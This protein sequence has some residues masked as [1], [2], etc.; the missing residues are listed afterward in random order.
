MIKINAETFKGFSQTHGHGFRA[1]EHIFLGM[2][3]RLIFEDT[4][5]QAVDALFELIERIYLI[6]DENY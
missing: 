1:L 5:E 4:S 2:L 3:L 6:L